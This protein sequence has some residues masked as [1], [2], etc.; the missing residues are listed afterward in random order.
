MMIAAQL[1]EDLYRAALMGESS[2]QAR[3]QPYVLGFLALSLTTSGKRRIALGPLRLGA[4]HRR[5]SLRHV[6]DRDA[7]GLGEPDA[8]FVAHGPA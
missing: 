7:Q 4:S 1:A 5:E 3:Q 8:D 2:W 6:G